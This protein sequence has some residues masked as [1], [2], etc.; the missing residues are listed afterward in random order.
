MKT[1]LYIKRHKTTGLLYFGKTTQSDPYSY[2]GSGVRWTRHLRVH[3]KDIETL[4]VKEF[5]DKDKLMKFA[6]LFSKIA[7]ITESTNWANIINENGIDGV[8]K[9]NEPWNKGK[10]QS[11]EHN[12]KIAES[13]K[14]IA[15]TKGMKM[16]K[17]AD[18]ARK[19][20]AKLA[21]KAK[22]RKRKYLPD[23]SW[24]WEYPEASTK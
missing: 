16:P 7:N 20:A 13:H 11:A 3:G 14:G 22:G 17:S 10:K 4:W 24:T 6:M 2:T 5:T 21:A 12:Q 18:N 19:G 23:G 1:Y 15:T 9:G 8:L